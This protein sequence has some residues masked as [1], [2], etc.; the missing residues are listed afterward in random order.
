MG[1]YSAKARNDGFGGA[2]CQDG[3]RWGTNL[4]GVRQSAALAV[5]GAMSNDSAKPRRI[6]PS[7]AAGTDFSGTTA[8][9]ADFRG[10]SMRLSSFM[11]TSR[12][13]SAENPLSSGPTHPQ[14]PKLLP[15]RL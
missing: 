4:R 14:N 7:T 13:N 11:P 5:R 3:E 2:T 15:W 6:G 10:N 12:R 9:L 1:G 8:K